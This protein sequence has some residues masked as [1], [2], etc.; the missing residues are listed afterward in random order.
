MCVGMACVW[1]G[2]ARGVQGPGCFITQ[3]RMSV[4]P[5]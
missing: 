4:N 2:G 1:G 5:F 3:I